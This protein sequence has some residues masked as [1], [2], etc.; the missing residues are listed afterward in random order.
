M[1]ISNT[2]QN[3]PSGPNFTHLYYSVI[4]RYTD[5]YIL[6]VNHTWSRAVPKIDWNGRKLFSM[7]TGRVA[8]A[9]FDKPR[10][11]SDSRK[12]WN[13][14]VIVWYCYVRDWLMEQATQSYIW[15]SPCKWVARVPECTFEQKRSN[16]N[17]D[18]S[19]FYEMKNSLVWAE[20]LMNKINSE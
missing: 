20:K 1:L 3:I 19:K 8:W 2:M 15:I 17:V 10:A 6:L 14:G 11:N 7:I 12:V 5:T 18:V 16:N 13:V 9:S 4:Y